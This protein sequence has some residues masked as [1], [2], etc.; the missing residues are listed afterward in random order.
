M[1]K[2]WKITAIVLIVI[3]LV[4]LALNKFDLRDKQSISIEKEWTFDANTLKNIAINGSSEN[5]EVTFVNSDNDSGSITLTGNFS[6]KLIEN[7]ENTVISGDSFTLDLTNRFEFHFLSLNFKTTKDR[8]V[9][10]LPNNNL[11]DNVE[12]STRSGNTKIEHVL[13]KNSS[14]S[15]LSGNMNV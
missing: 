1:S 14:F 15:T 4:G 9:V 13:A 3:G 8:I 12:I 6:E 11:L 10:T 7:I 5:L 2:K